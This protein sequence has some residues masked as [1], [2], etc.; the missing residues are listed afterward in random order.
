MNIE[1]HVY[2]LVCLQL[3]DEYKYSELFYSSFYKV[4]HSVDIAITVFPCPNLCQTINYGL[5]LLSMISWLKK[6]TT[7][8]CVHWT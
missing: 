7:F 1:A 8:L 3:I 2:T 4:K 6:K 5:H